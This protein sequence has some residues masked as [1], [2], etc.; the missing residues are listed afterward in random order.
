MGVRCSGH[1]PG[2]EG[3]ACFPEGSRLEQ[4]V[5]S[6]HES[7]DGWSLPCRWGVRGEKNRKVRG[8][9]E[10]ADRPTHPEAAARG[11]LRSPNLSECLPGRVGDLR[12]W[13]QADGG[14]KGQW[15][16]LIPARG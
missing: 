12:I 15:R 13:R 3:M 14:C 4:E 7:V 10:D 9:P 1:W 6:R 2:K 8:R 5:S 16:I 11:Q